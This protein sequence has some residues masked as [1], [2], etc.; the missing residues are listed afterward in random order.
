MD[1]EINDAVAIAADEVR[2]LRI[3]G[4]HEPVT[5]DR[6]RAEAPAD[7]VALL[8]VAAQADQLGRGRRRPPNLPSR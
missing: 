4:R 2:R 1:E 8:A 6:G 5:T 7:V 3:E